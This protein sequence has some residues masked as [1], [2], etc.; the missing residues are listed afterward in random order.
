MHPSR[1]TL[2]RKPADIVQPVPA[3]LEQTKVCCL[4]RSYVYINTTTALC[5]V[6]PARHIQE[7][8]DVHQEVN[9]LHCER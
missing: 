6:F 2:K 9:A 5:V 7:T 8:A 3:G 4:F 1:F